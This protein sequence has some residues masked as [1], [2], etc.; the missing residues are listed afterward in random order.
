MEKDLEDAQ[1]LLALAQRDDINYKTELE[2]ARQRFHNELDS[3]SK[4]RASLKKEVE[5]LRMVNTE[6]KTAQDHFEVEKAAWE[7]EKAS[8]NDSLALAEKERAILNDQLARAEKRAILAENNVESS[9][10]MAT[11]SNEKLLEREKDIEGFEEMLF[12]FLGQV[13]KTRNISWIP[14]YHVTLAN[15]WDAIVQS[16]KQRL[17]VDEI[18]ENELMRTILRDNEPEI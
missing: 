1:S 17:G 13:I 2:E 8:L 6:L 16:E 5:D 9:I 12:N 10:E 3:N 4:E 15:I 11:V 7:K 14:D 18:D